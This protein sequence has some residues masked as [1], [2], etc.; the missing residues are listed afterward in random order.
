MTG[1]ALLTRPDVQALG[2]SFSQDILKNVDSWAAQR[3][4]A[5]A[6][7]HKQR[8]RWEAFRWHDLPTMLG[9][10]RQGLARYG[11][12]AGGRLVVSGAFEPE[13]I[14]LVLAAHVAGVRVIPVDRHAQGERLRKTL[15]AA[16][17]T[18]AFV[19][20]RKTIASW[21][22]SG[23]ASDSPVTLFTSQ[24]TG[25]QHASWRIVALHTV[26]HAI[27][28]GAQRPG[29]VSDLHRNLHLQPVLW[30]DEGTEWHGGLEQVL[31][32]WLESG[33]VLAAPEVAASSARDRHEIQPRHF[34]ASAERR[35][36][37]QAEL[38]ERLPPPGS[39]QRELVGYAASAPIAR[40][41]AGRISRLHGLPVDAVASVPAGAAS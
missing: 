11:L 13:L 7:V 18:H 17:T 38:E 30:V 34:V 24:P 29:I 35:I 10:L 12:G 28:D 8:G 16:A 26:S 4:H 27:A 41:L 31:K 39:W 33:M 22:S 19:Q 20:D 3:P 2:A 32:T 25:H 1:S 9:R 15:Q 23:Y 36:Q 5:M 21:L 6:L 14:L 40:W 37:V